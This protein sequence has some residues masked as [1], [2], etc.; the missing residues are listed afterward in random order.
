Y[1][2]FRYVK[3]CGKK[4][5]PVRTEV[6]VTDI[7]GNLIN[8]ILIQCE[9]IGYGKEQKEDQNGLTIF[10]E[11]TDEQK[12]TVVSSNKDAVILDYIPKL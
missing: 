5:E 9:V 8:D 1:V 3:S 4:G 10:E 11:I 6:I 2:G 12:L 7:D